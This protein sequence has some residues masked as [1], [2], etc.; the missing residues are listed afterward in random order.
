MIKKIKIEEAEYE[1]NSNAYTRLLYKKTFNKG[2]M[3]DVK[4]IA[5]YALEIQ[6]EKDKLEKK[7]LSQ[8]EINTA[9]GVIALEKI[10]TFVEI[11]LQITYVFIKCND[12]KFMS[13]EDWL[14]TIEK[15]NPND[16]WVSEVT[17]LAVSS[18][19]RQ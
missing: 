7:G 11:I 14:K 1:I 6:N 13:Y 5:E 2:I 15:V 17:E 8:D 10:D 16:E 18:F 9:I 4:V 19:Y 3:E 12:E